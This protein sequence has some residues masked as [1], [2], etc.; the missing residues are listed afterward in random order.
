MD[1]I[2][3]LSFLFMLGSLELG[4]VSFSFSF[5]FLL[6]D[7]PDAFFVLSST[8]LLNRK[9]HSNPTHNARRS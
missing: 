1:P 9:P 7:L 5:C 8:G 2:E 3:A 6:V 4:R